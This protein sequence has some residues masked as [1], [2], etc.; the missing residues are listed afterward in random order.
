MGRHPQVCMGE[1]RSDDRMLLDAGKARLEL[2]AFPFPT[3][4]LFSHGPSDWGVGAEREDRSERLTERGHGRRMGRSEGLSMNERAESVTPE[5]LDAYISGELDPEVCERIER[6]LLDQ[7]EL[8]DRARQDG[9]IRTQLRSLFSAVLSEP[10][11]NQM[12]N[13]LAKRKAH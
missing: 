8:V 2:R 7:P 11:P 9:S 13:L 3:D 12:L 6:H 5:E 4:A 10:I 1:G